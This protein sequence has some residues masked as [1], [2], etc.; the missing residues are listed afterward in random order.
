MLGI[1]NRVL[2]VGH[3]WSGPSPHERLAMAVGLYGEPQSVLGGHIWFDV[4]G[5][6]IRTNEHTGHYHAN[7]RD[8]TRALLESV[9]GELFPTF[10][11]TH[12]D[13]T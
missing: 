4:A 5:R 11:H 10:E 13:W 7:W 12:E 3:I 8:E 2:A 6:R 9:M 1:P